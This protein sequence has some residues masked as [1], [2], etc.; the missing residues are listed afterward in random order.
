MSGMTIKE[1]V[2]D[3][4]GG[5]LMLHDSHI[6][7]TYLLKDVDKAELKR[8]IVDENILQRKSKQTALRAASTVQKRLAPLGKEFLN[9]ITSLPERSYVQLL[10]VALL[11]QSPVMADFMLNV[12]AEARRLYKPALDKDAWDNFIEE[13][14][15][16]WPE[17]ND[18]SEETYKKIGKNVIRALAE[19]GYLE[20]SRTKRIQAVYVVPE[21]INWLHKLN[22]TDLIDVMECTF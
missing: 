4:N 16:A 8:L 22:R 7:A 15:R 17:L 1:Y 3:I 21:V 2:G 6:L 19:A 12:L 20:S 18:Y 11:I 5:S 10:M 14:Q 13:R 9:D